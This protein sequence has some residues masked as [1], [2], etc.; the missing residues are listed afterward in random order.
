MWNWFTFNCYL[1]E[2]YI[3][4][5][6]LY[7]TLPQTLHL[8]GTSHTSQIHNA[9]LPPLLNFLSLTLMSHNLML[10]NHGIYDLC[11]FLSLNF[12]PLILKWNKCN[13]SRCNRHNTCM[14]SPIPVTVMIY[15]H[16]RF[17]SSSVSHLSPTYTLV[18]SERSKSIM[19]AIF[20][21]YSPMY[22][23]NY[24]DNIPQTVCS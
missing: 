10:Q 20:T 17:P 2:F 16:I 15:V 12:L 22:I 18:Y 1:L 9:S 8:Y 13:A 23:N 19:V 7:I 14:V 11:L 3:E 21:L 6:F 5:N 24:L 4:I